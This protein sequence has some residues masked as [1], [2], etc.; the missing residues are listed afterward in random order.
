M[1]ELIDRQAA[2]DAIKKT[3]KTCADRSTFERNI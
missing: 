1:S 3:G 2:L